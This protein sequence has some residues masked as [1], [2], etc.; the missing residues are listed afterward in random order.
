MVSNRA[1]GAEVIYQR[2]LVIEL[3]REGLGYAREVEQPIY[4]E[5]ILEI[6]MLYMNLLHPRNN[7]ENP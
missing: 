3:E 5:G 7:P 1:A 4:Y 6:T 2:C